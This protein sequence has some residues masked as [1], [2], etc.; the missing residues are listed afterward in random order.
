MGN[1]QT[2][3][4]VAQ[5]AQR[6]NF[7]AIVRDSFEQTKGLIA[8]FNKDNLK[9]GFL[10][11]G[12]PIRPEYGSIPYAAKKF[13]ENG[14]APFGTP[15]LFLTG[16]FQDAINIKVNAKSFTTFSTDSKASKLEL[17][18]SSKIYGL[19]VIKN[20]EYVETIKPIIVEKIKRELFGL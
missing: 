16:A 1:L 18:Y 5:N 3:R 4:K 7:D 6:I 13:N 17:K 15:D 11:T 9:K 8:S 19:P 20:S 12:D 10:A 14:M 2:I